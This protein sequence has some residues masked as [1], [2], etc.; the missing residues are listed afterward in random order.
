MKIGDLVK[1]ASWHVP[2]HCDQIGIIIKGPIDK[3][4]IAGP[5]LQT[6]FL[7]TWQDGTKEWY[8]ADNLE[9]YYAGR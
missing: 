6:I 2:W 9:R 5:S 3:V 1:P 7:V 8:N 4:A